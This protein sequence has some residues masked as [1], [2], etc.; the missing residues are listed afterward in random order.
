MKRIKNILAYM[1]LGIGS[2]I[3]AASCHSDDDAT[4]ATI[5]TKRERNSIKEGN[6]LYGKQRYAEAEVAYKK[7][8][9]ENPENAT[10]QFN[11]ASAYLK[12]RGED[13]TNKEDSLIRTADGMLA[14]VAQNPDRKLA[15]N[16]FYDR[17]N[18]AY[19]SED[20]AAA[21]EHYKNALR[22]NPDND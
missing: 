11:L 18:V 13:L 2:A 9:E 21:I 12:Q 3:M 4:P 15:E 17:G 19:K 16:S 14:K 5:S 1:V 6:D 7:A 20:Y 8:L 22:R 10:A